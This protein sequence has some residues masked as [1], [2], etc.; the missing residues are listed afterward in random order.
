DLVS[1]L[2]ARLTRLERQLTDKQEEAIAK[3]A[4]GPSVC[5]LAA[6]LLKS[7]D[8]DEVAKHAAAKL[9]LPASQEPADDQL[10]KAEQERMREAL[11]PFHNPAV[12]KAV[13]DAQAEL[14]Q[15]IDEQTKD[16]LV[17]AGFDADALE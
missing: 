5:E 14:T 10:A 15:V 17:R 4:G 11:K 8:P 9:N 1:T 6:S 2:A 16:G 13:L 7:I 12:R 3:A